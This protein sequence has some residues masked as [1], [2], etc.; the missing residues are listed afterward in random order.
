VRLRGLRLSDVQPRD[1]L[2]RQLCGRLRQLH[3]RR[4]QLSY[5]RPRGLTSLFGDAAVIGG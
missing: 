1:V 4:L 2:V 3:V 5:L